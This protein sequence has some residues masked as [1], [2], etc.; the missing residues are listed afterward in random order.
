MK[1]N[2]NRNGCPIIFGEV[3][4]DCFAD[5][6]TVLGGAPFNVAWH[7]QGLAM[8]P[9]LISCVGADDNAKALQAAMAEWGMDSSG[10]QTHPDYATGRVAV[11]LEKGQPSYDILADQAY[12][13]IDKTAALETI[14][15]T[16]ASLLYHGSLAIRSAESR[17]ALTALI[18]TTQ[19]PIFLDL[20]LRS[21]WWQ[22]SQFEAM[23]A[24]ASW[25][26]LNDEEL[27]EVCQKEM[28]HADDLKK[29]ATDLL[30][31]YTLEQL[32][33]TRGEQG[34]FIVTPNGIVEAQPVTV[35]SLVDTVGAGD[36]FCAVTIAGILQGWSLQKTLDR[37]LRFAA[38]ICQQQGATAPRL[39]LYQ[40]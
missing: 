24:R 16:P 19:L 10:L 28:S 17:Q 13:H 8:A 32:I 40:R 26:K 36:A 11:S 39:A 21:P 22:R 38:D 6:R 2:I 31:A 23:L 33:V 20:N 12:D 37:A 7:L 29:M 14:K 5:G 25:V 1:N 18:E 9:R 34:A 4:F 30:A 35:S 3:L 15:N 27:C